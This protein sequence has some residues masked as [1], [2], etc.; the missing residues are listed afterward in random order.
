MIILPE[1]IRPMYNAQGVFDKADIATRWNLDINSRRETNTKEIIGN[2]NIEWTATDES[3]VTNVGINQLRITRR[4]IT[5]SL[6]ETSPRQSQMYILELFYNGQEQYTV[7][8]QQK[9]LQQIFEKA[10]S[11]RNKSALRYAA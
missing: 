2:T 10:S 1:A 9:A 11:K 8:A 6:P 7:S 3:Y 5:D 4:K